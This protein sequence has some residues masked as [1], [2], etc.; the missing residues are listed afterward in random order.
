M[1]EVAQSLAASA[2]Q[3]HA[4]AQEL[5]STSE[6][7][8]GQAS[9]ARSETTNGVEVAERGAIDVQQTEEAVSEM[10]SAVA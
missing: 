4:S 6:V 1:I 3:S 8:V 9:H 2:E 10:E 5:T 7:I